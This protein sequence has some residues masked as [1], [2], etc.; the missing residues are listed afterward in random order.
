MLEHGTHFALKV[1]GGW[2]LGRANQVLRPVGSRGIKVV[3]KEPLTLQDAKTKG[4]HITGSYFRK[5]RDNTFTHAP[6]GD[7]TCTDGAQYHA[8]CILSLVQ[9]KYKKT[10]RGSDHVYEF[11][12]PA[13]VRELD[14]LAK[15]GEKEAAAL[16]Q[17]EDKKNSKK[18]KQR[19]H[20][21]ENEDGA[22]R[23]AQKQKLKE[24]RVQTTSKAGRAASFARGR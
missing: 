6:K 15:I 5:E 9:L 14:A 16:I 2:W 10:A 12:Y 21:G 19:D 23:A 7:D 22:G 18:Q 11:E 8:S 20:M 4:V 13:V 24:T 1:K 17:A 3:A